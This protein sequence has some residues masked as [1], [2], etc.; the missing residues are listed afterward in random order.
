MGSYENRLGAQARSKRTRRS[1]WF[2]V[3]A[4]EKEI[5]F[6]SGLSKNS[7]RRSDNWS[8][9][10]RLWWEVGGRGG[11]ER[12]RCGCAHCR[13]PNGWKWQQSGLMRSEAGAQRTGR[14]H[15]QGQTSSTEDS[16]YVSPHLCDVQKRQWVRY[17]RGVHS[18][19][20]RIRFSFPIWRARTHREIHESG[21]HW[22]RRAWTWSHLIPCCLI[23][24]ALR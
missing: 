10:D 6:H 19:P 18:L 21:S 7:Q 12:N 17:E 3:V 9:A 5:L 11:G 2:L 8:R 14:P 1:G 23:L 20:R 24:L 22:R 4:E 13:P 16:V 15:L